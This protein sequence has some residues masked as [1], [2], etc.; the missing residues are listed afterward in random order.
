VKSAAPANPPASRVALLLC[1]AHALSMTGF[2]T[3]PALLPVLR[4]AWGLSNSAAGAI[5]GMFFGGYMLAV[6]VLSS[7]TDRIDARRVYAFACALSS[8]GALGFAL[9]ADGFASAL[10]FQA[11]A[12]AGLAGTYMPGLKI[13]SD[14]IEGPRQSRW[15]AFYTSTFG[16]G[17]ALSLWMA[18]VSAALAGWRWAFG[19][20]AAGP[21]IAGALVILHLPPRRPAH[22][23]T[24]LPALLDFRPVFR[25]RALLG[26]VLAYAAHCWELFG[27]RSWIV[28]FFAF[29]ATLRTGAEPLLA[30]AASLAAVLNLLGQGASILGNELAV[31]LGRRRLILT[32]MSLSAA[33]ACGVGFAAPLPGAALFA[34]VAVYFII[35]MGDSA[36]LNAGLVAAA[37]AAQR[38]AAMAVHSFLGFGA[39]FLS[40]VAFGVVLDLSGG[41]E[42]VTAWGL[43]FAT[44]G[45][46]CALGPLALAVA[47]YRARPRRAR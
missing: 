3:F 31:R 33:L 28:A 41:N 12:G 38:G 15:I 43:A 25:Q 47:T 6:P 29:A 9:L 44:L 36:A 5:S 11:L 8:G 2:A 4:D 21:A 17:T 14:H 16:V 26:Y 34:L 19:I 42:S 1:G 20:A 45:V 24:A 22:P 7:L 30:S 32:T 37:P 27:V 18:G 46:G 23:S 10:A 39:G 40:P 13:L 35:I